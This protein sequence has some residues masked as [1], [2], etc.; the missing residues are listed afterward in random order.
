MN[1]IKMK[2]LELLGIVQKNCTK[3]V[4]DFVEAVSDYK[5]AVVQVS[6]ANLK[7]AKTA[8][9]DKIKQIKGL[10]QKP[11]SYEDSY[12]RAIRMLELSVEDIIEVEEDVFNQLV[13][14]EWQWKQS[15]SA[16]NALYKTVLSGASY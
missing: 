14:D 11:V 16:S 10:P 5:Q 7:L 8:D 3:H 6:T 13:L 4:S 12:K 15:F 1:S 9:L 2:R